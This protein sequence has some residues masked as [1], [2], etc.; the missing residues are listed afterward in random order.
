MKNGCDI[1]MPGQQ[2]YTFIFENGQS[3]AILNPYFAEHK[4]YQWQQLEDHIAW[5]EETIAFDLLDYLE[6]HYNPNEIFVYRATK[7]APLENTA[8]RQPLRSLH[9]YKETAWIDDIID[10]EQIQS[11]Y[12]PIVQREYGSYTIIGHELLSRGKGADGSTIAPF[13]LLEAARIRNRLFA[14]DRVCRM[15]SVKNAATIKDKLIFINFI[16]T[17]IYVPEHCLST[18]IRLI[19]ERGI[20]PENVVFEVVES[21]EVQDIGHLKAI[22]NYYRKHGFK[23]ALDDVG[24]GAND[25][26]KLSY[27]E[28]DIV[29]L[30]REYSDGVSRDHEKQKVAAAL[31]QVAAH[32]GSQPLA[33]GIE[34]KEDA[35]YLAEMGYEL[36]QGYY[37]AK[38]QAQPLDALPRTLNTNH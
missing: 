37:F 26:K 29:K 10:Q 11:H 7:D 23:Y 21:D 25:L 27:L 16:P 35:D 22:L 31:L 19:N 5:M 20:A 8:A 3:P 13:F 34:R 32:T 38:P 9:D 1:C 18:T 12:Q 33:E 14:L 36:F 15:A 2:G 24:T 17:A 30:A 28:P 6:V 4:N